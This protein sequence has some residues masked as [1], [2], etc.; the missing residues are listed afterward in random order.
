MANHN[1]LKQQNE[2][3]SNENSKQMHVTGAKRGKT[4]TTKSRFLLILHLIGWIGGASFLNQSQS[5]VKQNQSNLV[6]TFDSHLK[7][8]L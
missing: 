6:I 3:M 8:A 4:R 1:K 5:V 7:T 2:P